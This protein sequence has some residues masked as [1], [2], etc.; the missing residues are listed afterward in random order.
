V[1]LFLALL[2]AFGSDLRALWFRPWVSSQ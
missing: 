2:V 1:L